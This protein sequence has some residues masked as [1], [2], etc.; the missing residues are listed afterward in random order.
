MFSKDK[1]SIY[2][3]Q[4]ISIYYQLT[5]RFVFTEIN[6]LIVKF[7]WQCKGPRTGH[8]ILEKKEKLEDSHVPVSKLIIKLQQ[9]R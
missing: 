6:C 9:L 5:I 7:I 3:K 2:K 8:L 4:F 1:G